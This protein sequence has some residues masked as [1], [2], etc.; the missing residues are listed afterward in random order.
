MKY[1][2]AIFTLLLLCSPVFAES[3]AV[4]SGP[5]E[6]LVNNLFFLSTEGSISDNTQWIL[7]DMSQAQEAVCGTTKFIVINRPGRYEFIL[8]AADKAANI[9]YVRHTVTVRTSLDPTPGPIDPIPDPVIPTPGWLDTLTAA[10]KA[11]S[12]YL[13]DPPTAAMLADAINTAITSTSTSTPM[14][15]ATASMSKTIEATLLAR[16]AV[17]RTKDWLNFWRKPVNAELLKLSEAGKIK[18]TEEYLEA[19]KAVLS[20]LK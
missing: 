5:S 19:M 3:K 16:A 9:S 11:G 15:T 2:Q 12:D 6:V 4:I 7:P 20:G 8:V 17:S 1:Y 13:S 14:P 18:T 10:S